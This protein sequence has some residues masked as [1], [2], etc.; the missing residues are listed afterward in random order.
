[1]VVDEDLK[2][3]CLNVKIAF[4]FPPVDLTV[5]A[6]EFHEIYAEARDRK[7]QI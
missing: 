4:Y 1:M 6:A 5:H 3:W 2:L 7:K